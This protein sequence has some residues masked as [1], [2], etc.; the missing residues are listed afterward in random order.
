MASRCFAKYESSVSHH[1]A[2]LSN[3]ATREEQ[4]KTRCRGLSYATKA[5]SHAGLHTRALLSLLV[6]VFYWSSMCSAV[7]AAGTDDRQ[8][9]LVQDDLV[10]IGSSLLLDHRPPPIAPL[11]MPPV[12]DRDDT[13]KTLY[14]P[15]KRSITTDT[16]G[17]KADFEI[18]K[19]FDTGLSNNFTTSCAKFL[20]RMRT[21]DAFTSCHPFSLLL[22]TSSGFFDASKS[23][24][25]ITQTLDATCGV[26]ATQCRTT[27]D[28]FAKDLMSS[29][30]CKTDYDNNN[31]LVLQ[32][33]NGLVAYQPAYQASC[34]KDTEG[35]YCF[36]NAVSNTS[37]PTDSYAYYLPIGQE[38]PGGSRP[39]CNSCLQQAMGVFSHYANNVTQPVSKTYTSAAQQLSISCGSTFVN[40]TAAPLKGAASTSTSSI[41]PT[42][43]LVLMFV[44][45]IFQ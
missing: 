12:R 25:R 43:T 42:M 35:N 14:I 3:M 31:P 24:L 29:T 26:D 22:Q 5:S 19:P 27:L 32:A 41:T 2:P 20:N 8:P 10:W 30:A 13:T 1:E 40:V 11:L 7:A 44:L 33:Y 9:L 17:S 28:S 34:L 37:S 21:D 6:V 15:S 36:A 23:I 45:Y 38:M 4:H 39:T 16:K 18:P